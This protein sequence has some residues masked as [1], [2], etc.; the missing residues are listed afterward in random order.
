MELPMSRSIRSCLAVAGAFG[1]FVVAVLLQKGDPTSAQGTQS[2]AVAVWDFTKANVSGKTVRDSV[3]KL[4]ATIEGHPVLLDKPTAFLEF[5]TDADTVVVRDKVAPDAQFLPKTAFT[6][7]AWV[8]IDQP[9][10]Y[11]GIAGI[12]QDNGSYEK[13][14]LLGYS[15]DAFSFSLA[16]EKD[17]PRKSALTTVKSKVPFTKGQWAYVAATYD[18]KAMRLF[19]N[20]QLQGE[21]P[22]Q[23]GPVAYA[24]SAPF[25][26]GRY[27]DDNEDYPMAG[28]IKRVALYH[29]ALSGEEIAKQFEEHKPLTEL[30]P[31]AVNNRFVIAPYLQ[32]PTHT[33]MTV[34]WE[35]QLPGTSVVEYGPTSSQL[36][37]V[38]ANANATM[39]EVVLNDLPPESKFIYRVSTTDATGTTLTS[40]TYQFMTSVKA[41][42][43]FTFGVVGD[44]QANPRVTGRIAEQIYKRRPHLVLH[45]GDVVDSG[46]DKRQWV[47]ELFGPCVELFS[48]VPVMPTIGNHERNHAFYYKYFS[49]PKP[50]YYHKFTYGNAEFFSLDSNKPLGPDSEQYKW[51]DAEL[52]KSKATWK[53]AYHHHPAYSS[54][55]NDYG[56]TRKGPSTM[57]DLNARKLVE[58]YEKHKVDVV[59]NGH[60]HLYERSWPIKAGKVDRKNGVV[61]VTSGGGGGNLEDFS[62]LPN[63]F[64]AMV[65]VD[66][67]YCYVAING[68]N[69][70]LKAFDQNGNL[71]DQF[72][73]DK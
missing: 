60:I 46:P 13:G 25:M 70:D 31:S 19:V 7:D 58:L 62:P 16:A 54:D 36:K 40:Q 55:E 69:F 18:G 35:T 67:H 48:R 51:L 30:P 45:C 2:G 29:R 50:E 11:G 9:A 14:F 12:L 61:H 21:S 43:P 44:T 68:N 23:S 52:A 28:A 49:L 63:W 66:F 1:V 32:S 57:G 6:I 15:D 17:D 34:M 38:E 3:G 22:E 5:Q 53:I 59:F 37:K 39:H 24:P 72:S 10:K 47:Q 41:D 56:D 4:H 26:I 64:K 73:I 20:G 71:F 27:R 65:R 33:S 8:R 42:S